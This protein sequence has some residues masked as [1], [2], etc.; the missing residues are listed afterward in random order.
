MT[1]RKTN[2]HSHFLFDPSP[3]LASDHQDTAV[4]FLTLNFHG[5]AEIRRGAAPCSEMGTSRKSTGTQY[6]LTF[7]TPQKSN[8]TTWSYH[9]GYLASVR[10]R[11]LRD[12]FAERIA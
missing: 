12:D 3:S 9:F 4:R 6:H 1:L 5:A 10:S 8:G 7:Y 11:T 2:Y